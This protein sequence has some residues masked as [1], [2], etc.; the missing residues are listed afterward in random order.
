MLMQLISRSFGI[1][2]DFGSNGYSFETHWSHCVLSLS[3]TCYPVLSTRQ[4]IVP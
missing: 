1:E 3:K 4:E 2:L